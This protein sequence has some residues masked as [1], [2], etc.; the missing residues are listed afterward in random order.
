MV[1]LVRR[2]A[3]GGCPFSCPSPCPSHGLVWFCF[4]FVGWSVL[5][6]YLQ[7]LHRFNS[8]TGL[9]FL[10]QV[11]VAI[12]PF[13]W[14]VLPLFTYA[15]Q[16]FRVPLNLISHKDF[17]SSVTAVPLKSHHSS[18]SSMR[19]ETVPLLLKWP[20]VSLLASNFRQYY[21]FLPLIYSSLLH[22]IGSS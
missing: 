13:L 14:D 7:S 19:S 9:S 3:P 6:F 1:V 17:P 18:Q 12:T 2:Q 22:L 15:Q 8:V 21:F 16:A 11:L 5:L 10:S 20:N 4:L